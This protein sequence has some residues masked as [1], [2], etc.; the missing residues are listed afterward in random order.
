MS[1]TW[2]KM[3]DC[4]EFFGR[5]NPKG[6][7]VAHAFGRTQLAHRIAWIFS[8]GDIPPGLCVCHHC[9]NPPC[10]N[11]G[12]LFIGTNQDNVDD[13]VSKGRQAKGD[14]NGSHT[15]PD[16]R[17]CGDRN[18]SRLHPERLSRGD[19]HYSRTEPD[20]LARGSRHGRTTHPE[21][22]PRGESNLMAKLNVENVREIRR[23]Y[24]EGSETQKSLSLAFAVS[25]SAI[26]KIVNMK[27]WQ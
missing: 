4:I 19:D 6:Y 10:I 26:Y 1:A 3:D 15:Q 9:D 11:P 5:R 12:H 20:R 2:M 8:F 7:G 25:E 24:S 22:R 27:T 21:K 16:K 18:G 14:L 23:L 13:C 17:A